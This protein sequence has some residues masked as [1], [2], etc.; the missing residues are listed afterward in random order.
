MKEVNR[1]DIADAAAIARDAQKVCIYTY[2][3]PDDDVVTNHTYPERKN[4]I[5]QIFGPELRHKN[6]AMRLLKTISLLIDL[7]HHLC[8][9][10]GRYDDHQARGATEASDQ[11]HSCSGQSVCV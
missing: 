4:Q 3:H 5:T 7:R 1:T 9:N 10:C 8:L 6:L 2:P 11:L